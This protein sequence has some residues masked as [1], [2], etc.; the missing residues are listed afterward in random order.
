M[1]TKAFLLVSF[2]AIGS[3][4]GRIAFSLRSN[5]A[6][7]RLEPDWIHL[8]Q[9]VSN[10]LSSSSSLFLICLKTCKHSRDSFHSVNT[11]CMKSFPISKPTWSWSSRSILYNYIHLWSWLSK[12]SQRESWAVRDDLC[13]SPDP[14]T[15][16]NT[17]IRNIQSWLV[18]DVSH[19]QGRHT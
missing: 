13:N 10:R 3:I 4:P 5:S 1:Q 14:S 8:A 18:G 16:T 7:V 2:P 17:S 9:S 11:E 19:L 6:R 15:Q 12:I